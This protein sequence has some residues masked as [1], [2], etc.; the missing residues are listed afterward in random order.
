[1]N[2]LT[3]PTSACRHCR[4]YQP[5]GRRGGHCEQLGVPVRGG[6]KACSLAIPP[7]APSWETVEALIAWQQGRFASEKP[8]LLGSRECSQENTY[9]RQR[10]SG[11]A[12]E[13]ATALTA[14]TSAL[15]V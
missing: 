11:A 4:F 8:Q 5:E 7:F 9:S 2:T 6:W 3:C 14:P 10:E 12:R 13:N 1:M 15:L